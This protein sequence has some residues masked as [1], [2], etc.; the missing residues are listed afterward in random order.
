MSFSLSSLRRPV[1]S[2]ATPGATDF[3]GWRMVA[4]AGFVVFCAAPGMTYGVAAFVD[5][6]TSDLGMSRS[7]LSLAYAI[8]TLL[9]AFVLLAIGKQ[10]DRWGGRLVMAIAA[11]GLAIG[12]VWLSFSAGPLWMFVGFAL[13]RTFGQGVMPLAARIIVPHWFFRQRGR[14]FSMIGIAGTLS[15]AT[16]PPV[17]EWLIHAVGWRATWRIDAIVLLVVVTPIILLFLRNTPEDV[18]Q[19]PDGIVPDPEAP[20]AT[21]DASGGMSLREAMH[22]PAFWGLVVVSAVGF[23]L[24]SGLALNQVAIFVDL[25]YPASLAALTFTVESI[26]MFGVTLAIG[27]LVDRYPLRYSL[28]LSQLLLVVGMAV[29]LMAQSFWLGAVYAALRG[30]SMA[31]ILVTVDVAWPAFFGRKQLGSVRGFGAA[32][33]VFGTAM[34]PLPFGFAYDAFGSYAPAIFVL[35]ALPALAGLFVLTTR[36]PVLNQGAR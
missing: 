32:I 9:S 25:G 11:I 14:A 35:L 8:A 5:P 7:V 4:L 26:A 20:P 15:I 13:T 2:R 18:G 33:G 10:I 6:V 29:L 21:S 19:Y 12:V 28:A 30:A 34:V 22:T 31:I 17:H 23:G 24:T 16:M 3:S 36:P 27:T 1:L